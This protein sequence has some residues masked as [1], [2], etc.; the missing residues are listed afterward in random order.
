MKKAF[1]KRLWLL[2]GFIAFV[3]VACSGGTNTTEPETPEEA[4]QETSETDR[5]T[6]PFQFGKAP[7]S[8]PLEIL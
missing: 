3:L 5:P 1:S 6:Q 7:L 4:G 2:V 8:R